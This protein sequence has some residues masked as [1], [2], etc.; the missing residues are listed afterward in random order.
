MTFNN[1]TYQQYSDIHM[2]WGMPGMR[3]YIVTDLDP[4]ETSATWLGTETMDDVARDTGN[5]NTYAHLTVQSQVMLHDANWYDT[6]RLTHWHH[7]AH[8]K[9]EINDPDITHYG[10]AELNDQLYGRIH[11][12]MY[13]TTDPPSS[14]QQN[15][16]K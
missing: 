12:Y 3:N 10:R 8:I 11:I 2:R 15:P 7:I 1:I 13:L 16:R 5:R 9:P 14:H 6:H 4:M